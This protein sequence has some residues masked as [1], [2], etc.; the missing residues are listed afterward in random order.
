MII[1]DNRMWMRIFFYFLIIPPFLQIFHFF[2]SPNFIGIR[3]AEN[4]KLCSDVK[5]VQFFGIQQIWVRFEGIASTYSW[6][7]LTLKH[8][9]IKIQKSHPKSLILKISKKMYKNCHIIFFKKWKF[10]KKIVFRINSFS[11]FLSFLQFYLCFFTIFTK[12]K[13][14]KKS[15]FS[16]I[17]IYLMMD[18]NQDDKK[19]NNLFLQI[20]YFFSWNIF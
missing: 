1:F 8:K 12:L 4:F 15:F 19:N 5:K 18:N 7:K 20:I 16:T 11:F 10:S 14:K 13:A 6:M 9:K 2:S 3:F 17:I